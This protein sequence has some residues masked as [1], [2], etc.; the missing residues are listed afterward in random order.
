[1]TPTGNLVR[2]TSLYDVLSGSVDGL[3]S[4]TYQ[5]HSGNQL[6]HAIIRENKALYQDLLQNKERS[7]MLASSIIQAIHH[8]G[9]RFLRKQGRQWLELLDDQVLFLTCQALASDTPTQPKRLPLSLVARRRKPQKKHSLY[10]STTPP[11]IVKNLFADDIPNLIVNHTDKAERLIS[12]RITDSEQMAAT[13]T[14]HEVSMGDLPAL[15]SSETEDEDDWADLSPLDP[16][17]KYAAESVEFYG[18]CQ[19]LLELWR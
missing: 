4:S 15:I 19:E 6:F 10:S 13:T 2:T 9:G 17:D 5:N 16:D 1:M 11:A 14:W 3:G 7:Q 18:L 12:K 8:L